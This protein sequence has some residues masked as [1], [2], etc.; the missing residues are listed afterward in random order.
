MYSSHQNRMKMDIKE[1]LEKHSLWL[2]H[3]GGERAYLEGANLERAY[4]EGANLEGANL[5]GANLEGANLEGANLFSAE[6]VYSFGPMPTSGRIC[7][8]VY[9]G[10]ETG[11]KV[12]A[13]CFWGSLDELEVK[14]KGSHN[15][16]VYLANIALLRG[17]KPEYK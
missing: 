13:G 10:A 3:E 15:C 8:A 7:Y 9:H 5:E 14:V 2:A 12:K 4:L 16:P 17:W 6:W 11:W 1:I